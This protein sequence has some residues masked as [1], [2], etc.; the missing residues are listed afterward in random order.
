[1]SN[2]NVVENQSGA[3]RAEPQSAQEYALALDRLNRFARIT[4]SCFRIPFTRIRF[5]LSPVIGLIPVLGDIFGLILS[6]YVIVEARRLRAPRLLQLRMV[7]N[8]V[9][10]AVGGVLP[11]V[12]DAFDVWFKAN[13]RNLDLLCHH[14][15]VQL[16]PPPRRRYWPWLVLT[17]VAMGVVV[18]VLATALQG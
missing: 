8:A 13:T 12:G 18:L 7:F 10:E 15:R 9:V 6:V 5:G 1:M 2:N 3:A 17:L 14:L 11:V 4:D 16:E